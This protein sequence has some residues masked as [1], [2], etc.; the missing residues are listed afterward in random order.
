MANPFH[1]HEPERIVGLRDAQDYADSGNPLALNFGSGLLTHVT[2][3]VAANGTYVL[4]SKMA[5]S[6]LVTGWAYALASLP[7]QANVAFRSYANGKALLEI[8]A[9]PTLPSMGY[10]AVADPQVGTCDRQPLQLV[11]SRHHNGL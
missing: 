1:F 10:R 3:T 6:T 11:A 9:E 4:Q 8:T 7:V 2:F 5:S